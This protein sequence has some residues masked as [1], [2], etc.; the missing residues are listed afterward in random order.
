MCLGFMPVFP[1]GS[2]AS[3]DEPVHA[4][5]SKPSASSTGSDSPK[6]TPSPNKAGAN[7][8]HPTA[9]TSPLENSAE[10]RIELSSGGEII[11]EAQARY[12]A[13]LEAESAGD[14]ESAYGH[15]QAAFDSDPGLS[16]VGL[17]LAAQALAQ[18]DTTRAIATLD[19]MRSRKPQDPD[20]LASLSFGYAWAGQTKAARSLASAAIGK[21]SN[22][23]F[24]HAVLYD[25]EAS[26]S[27]ATSTAIT[28][29]EERAGSHAKKTEFW[30]S[31]GEAYARLLSERDKAT[32]KQMASKVLPLFQRA[33]LLSE[34]YD[35]ALRVAGLLEQDGKES[36]AI[37]ALEKA[38]KIK[39]KESSVR[40][41]LAMLCVRQNRIAD[42]A[43]HLE[44]FL[45]LEPSRTAVTPTLADLYAQLNN[46]EKYRLYL[47]QAA[48]AGTDLMTVAEVAL[49]HKDWAGA[50]KY[51]LQAMEHSSSDPNLWSRLAHS[52]L[53]LNK[54]T[55]AA[56]TMDRAAEQFPGSIEVILATAAVHRTVKNFD[57]AASCLASAEKM[58]TDTGEPTQREAVLFEQGVLAEKMDRMDTARLHFDELIRL[59]PQHHR[60]MNYISYS[61]ADRKQN[62]SDAL[63]LVEKA[64]TLDPGNAAYLDTLGWIYYRQGQYS[65][66]L[67]KIR[68]ALEI[69]PGEPEMLEHLGDIYRKLGRSSDAVKVWQESLEADPSRPGLREKIAELSQKIPKKKPASK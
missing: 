9:Q 40:V 37:K 28:T 66:A 7:G 64:L 36:G 50:E 15:F 26:G 63:S 38:V 29:V 4:P 16:D 55:E 59:N 41:R 54:N 5:P 8:E 44:A 34:D 14:S 30:V 18:K 33:S 21:K 43:R 60:A 53:Q 35:L 25:L 6:P 62:L 47:D 32:A 65:K 67:E 24:A 46:K 27:S 68:E 48:A 61:W 56:A 20:L 1:G 45:E 58:A 31:V 52:Q 17:R 49:R 2:L 12:A 39:P 57:R 22:H 23:A 13:G 19:K 11:A 51:L 10:R 42:A 3:T 69:E